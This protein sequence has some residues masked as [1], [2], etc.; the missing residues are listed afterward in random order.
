MTESRVED[1][2]MEHTDTTTNVCS[3]EVKRPNYE[4][5]YLILFYIQEGDIELSDKEEL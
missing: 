5:I 3:I 1:F 2:I 4:M